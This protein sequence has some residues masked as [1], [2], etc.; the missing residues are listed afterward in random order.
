MHRFLQA[1]RAAAVLNAVEAQQCPLDANARSLP[2][3]RVA[4]SLSSL[5]AVQ[6][7][8]AI[9]SA[10]G[11]VRL[12]AVYDVAFVVL[13]NR[14]GGVAVVAFFGLTTCSFASRSF[15]ALSFSVVTRT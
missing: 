14:S 2:P 9:R 6:N 7:L 13:D 8:T 15:R 11:G 3:L 10:L 5:H 1:Q 12:V 4:V